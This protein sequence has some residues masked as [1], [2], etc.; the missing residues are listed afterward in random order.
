MGLFSLLEEEC[1]LARTTDM[2]FIDKLNKQMSKPDLY[3][4]SK[5]RDPVFGIVHYAG[6]VCDN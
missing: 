4:K 3:K 1:L 6:L 5:H 2:S